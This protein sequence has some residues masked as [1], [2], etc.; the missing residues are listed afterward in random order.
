MCLVVA[1]AE[2]RRVSAVDIGG[3]YLNADRDQDKGVEV[4]YITELEHKLVNI[5]IKVVPAHHQRAG[6]SRR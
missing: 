4:I 3:A 5:H 6:A 1:A 2:G